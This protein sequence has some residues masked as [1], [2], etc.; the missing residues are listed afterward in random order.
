MLIWLVI[1]VFALPLV[2]I[3]FLFLR[4]SAMLTSLDPE[5]GGVDAAMLKQLGIDPSRPVQLEFTLSFPTRESAAL[6][7]ADFPPPQWRTTLGTVAGDEG[8]P[9]TACTESVVNKAI[10][11]ALITLCRE[12]ASTHGGTF[13]GWQVQV[14]R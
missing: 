9:C 1:P 8:W 10:L 4:R 2:A 12:V 6:A 3:G 11:D 7:A 13:D 5:G 14:T